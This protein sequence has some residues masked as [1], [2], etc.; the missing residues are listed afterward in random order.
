MANNAINIANYTVGASGAAPIF[1][2]DVSALFKFDPATNTVFN[3][4]LKV[5]KSFNVIFSASNFAATTI[6]AMIVDWVLQTHM[7]LKDGRNNN[8]NIIDAAFETA[9]NN[10]Q[11]VVDAIAKNSGNIVDYKNTLFAAVTE[12]DIEKQAKALED[13]DNYF[14]GQG[15]LKIANDVEWTTIPAAWC[16]RVNVRY[17]K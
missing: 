16:L 10:M 7:E 2:S 3:G 13:I 1:K 12:K 4:M 15:L 17:R 14:R 5:P 9:M 8:N 6:F 11:R